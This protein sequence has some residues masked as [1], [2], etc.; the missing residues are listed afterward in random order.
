MSAN[1]YS[2]IWFHVLHKGLIV[3]LHADDTGKTSFN[4]LVHM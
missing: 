1:A 2:V 4:P 3:V